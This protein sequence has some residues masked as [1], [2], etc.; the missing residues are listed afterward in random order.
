MPLTN[1]ERQARYKA[2]LRAAA[3]NPIK[4]LFEEYLIEWLEQD[5]I[6]RTRKEYAYQFAL[7]FTHDDYGIETIFDMMCKLIGVSNEPW[8]GLT[9][10]ELDAMVGPT[11]A[12]KS[13]AENCRLGSRYRSRH[14]QPE[15]TVFPVDQAR[16]YLIR[17]WL[18]QPAPE[19]KAKAR[20]GR[21]AA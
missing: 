16:A 3:V 10:G 21:L 19:T 14:Q 11:R 4:A 9:Y 18:K 6:K 5:E 12:R 17:K 1:A 2:R 20:K 7:G 15:A 8:P 13:Y